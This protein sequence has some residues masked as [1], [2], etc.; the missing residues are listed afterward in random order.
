MPLGCLSS[1]FSC[2]ALIDISLTLE[3][4]DIPVADSLRYSEFLYWMIDHSCVIGCRHAASISC[5]KEKQRVLRTMCERIFFLC[6]RAFILQL[7]TCTIHKNAKLRLAKAQTDALVGLIRHLHSVVNKGSTHTFTKNM[8]VICEECLRAL[9]PLWTEYQQRKDTY[10]P[11]FVEEEATKPSEEIQKQVT[12]HTNAVPGKPVDEKSASYRLAYGM[13]LGIEASVRV[14]DGMRV[15][16]K[17]LHG[18]RAFRDELQILLKDKNTELPACNPSCSEHSELS[19]DLID[20][21]LST[22]TLFYTLPE[23]GSLFSPKHILGSSEDI[24]FE[25]LAPALFAKVRRICNV[26]SKEYLRS[27]TKRQFS[28]IQFQTNSKSGEMFFF[29]HNGRF[30]LKT[31]SNREA[32]TLLRMLPAYISHVELGAS[33]LMRI[34]GLYRFSTGTSRKVRHVLVAISVMDCKALGLHHQFDLKGS[35]VGRSAGPDHNVQKDCDW[36]DGDWMVDL[37][38]EHKRRIAEIQQADAEFLA[39]QQVLDYS[40]L[41]GIHDRKSTEAGV[42]CRSVKLLASI[43]SN[44]VMPMIRKARLLKAASSMGDTDSESGHGST[45]AFPSTPHDLSLSGAAFPAAPPPTATAEETAAPGLGPSQSVLSTSS[46]R[47]SD[48]SSYHIKPHNSVAAA[49]G[50]SKLQS[51]FG[52][53]GG[54]GAEVSTP[55]SRQASIASVGSAAGI[56]AVSVYARAGRCAV[57]TYAMML[58]GVRD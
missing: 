8:S 39:Q 51:L 46:N 2:T 31:I 49:N 34:C 27:V 37:P 56:G 47:G 19:L 10:K 9:E 52:P 21:A 44:K 42:Q 15:Y 14:E 33:F 13:M 12:G 11:F 40:V 17:V 7:T 58:G 1:G 29:S 18:M 45:K 50:M 24:W 16:N 5:V 55:R 30:L 54:A 57:L 28:F 4:S 41:I 53:A 25:D 38:A 35:T 48:D 32:A 20:L 26:E 6:T 36:L 3:A 43:I 23:E 22:I